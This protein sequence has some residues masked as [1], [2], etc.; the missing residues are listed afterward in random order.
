MSCRCFR[1]IEM[2]SSSQNH[3]RPGRNAAMRFSLMIVFFATVCAPAVGAGNPK[4][5]AEA[6]Q[7]IE[8]MYAGDPDAAIVMFRGL[9][10]SAPYDPFGFLL[11][12]EARWWKIYCASLDVKWGYVDAFKRPK[13]PGD[14]EY[15]ALADKVIS[16]ASA[17]YAKTD[18]AEMRLYSGLGGALK[19]RYYGLQGDH[20]AAARAG[21][22]ARQ[23]FL[24]A[25]QLDPQM[26]DAETGIG[27]YNYF[28]D[29]LSA[30]VKVLRF[31]M[32]LPGGNKQDGI[33]QL[34]TA[35][36]GGGFTSV[37]ARFYLTKSLRTYDQ[38]YSRAETLIEPLVQRYPRN[39]IF[40]LLLA[41]LNA[42]LGRNDKAA[43]GFKSARDLV[44]ADSACAA[45]VQQVVKMSLAAI[46]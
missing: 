34:E 30:A 14:D 33:R 16:L 44:V 15:L 12:G 35:M 9:Q 26:T 6:Q 39:P 23:E 5:P 42:E 28:V 1:A 41:N 24:L 21:V 37:D 31:F 7:G 2:R 10:A 36:N 25:S 45:H 18:S 40:V 46:H 3:A 38:Q 22:R 8:K 20:I 32:G 13:Q 43:A 27:L 4:L 29:T 19:A 17:Q 11:E